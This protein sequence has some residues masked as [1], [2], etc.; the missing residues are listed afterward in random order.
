MKFIF[1]ALLITLILS[2][3][4]FL[5][6]FTEAQGIP[7]EG[8]N[9]R[10]RLD[11]TLDECSILNLDERACALLIYNRLCLPPISDDPNLQT[12]CAFV[13]IALSIQQ[14]SNGAQ[15]LLKNPSWSNENP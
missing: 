14:L 15:N 2:K 11:W 8:T 13:G 9:W 6:E 4:F 3:L 10:T 5:A 12:Y 1:R 7:S